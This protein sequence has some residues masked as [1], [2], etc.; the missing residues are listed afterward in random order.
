MAVPGLRD[1]P[2]DA[3]TSNADETRTAYQDDRWER[4]DEL[5][6]RE[7][8]H[9]GAALLLGALALLA[10]AGVAWVLFQVLG[11]GT[12]PEEPALVPVPSTLTMSE[13]R[14]REVLTAEGFVVP[15]ATDRESDAE[16]GTVID[17]D[18]PGGLAQEGSEVRIVLSA[19][20][21]AI[22]IPRLAGFEEQAARDELERLG[23]TNIRA[24][25]EEVDDPDVEEGLVI[26]TDPEEGQEV[27]PDREIVLRVSSGQVEVPDV[28]DETRDEA[29]R[30][31]SEASL[32]WQVETQQTWEVEA[33]TVMDQS[34]EAGDI[35]DQ[36][37]EV[38]I[39]VAETPP[40]TV[41]VTNEPPPP[42]PPVT[43]DPPPPPTTVEPTTDP[44]TTEP[45]PTPDP[46]TDPTDP[47]TTDPT[48]PPTETG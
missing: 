13:E 42:P 19:G 48:D 32:R 45:T 18:P 24:E 30:L 31:L 9:P 34:V 44:P 11:T 27:E 22:G 46:T 41:T 29:I 12:D 10:V 28:V 4:T 47:P 8:R 23:F 1:G 5:P 25:A 39:V 33:G 7:R 36:D 26:G 16:I 21:D 15:E 40:S 6:V 20:P 3:G 37:T 2:G 35:V 38:T 14:A 43:T 17:Q